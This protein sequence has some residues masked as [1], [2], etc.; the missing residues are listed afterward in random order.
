MLTTV[1]TVILHYGIVNYPDGTFTLSNSDG[2]VISVQPDGSL[3]ARP[4]GT[5]GPY[6]TFAGTANMAT[7]H[8]GT[9]QTFGLLDISGI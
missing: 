5:H 3:E 6:E 9:Y 7:V 1:D 4:E 8:S 2:S